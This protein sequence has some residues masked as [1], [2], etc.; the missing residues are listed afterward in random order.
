MAGIEQER[1]DAPERV[2]ARDRTPEPGPAPA[3]S[4]TAADAALSLQRAVGNRR[5]ARI[6][7][8]KPGSVQ[9]GVAPPIDE[10]ASA[11]E[12]GFLDPALAPR[13]ESVRK[14]V[15]QALKVAG[16]VASATPG[17]KVKVPAPLKLLNRLWKT[18]DPEERRK[19]AERLA[20]RPVVSAMETIDLSAKLLKDAFDVFVWTAKTGARVAGHAQMLR[21]IESIERLGKVPEFLGVAVDAYSAV[22]G[23]VKLL[24]PDEKSS[25]RVSGG[26]AVITGSTKA[27]GGWGTLRAG[28]IKLAPTWA[29]RLTAIGT[30][31]EIAHLQA[32][33]LAGQY[34][35]ALTG[36]TAPSV[37]REFD[38]LGGAMRELAGARVVARHI[39]EHWARAQ[40]GQDELAAEA[41]EF[42]LHDALRSYQSSLNGALAVFN[43]LRYRAM[44]KPYLARIDELAKLTDMASADPAGGPLVVYQA[45]E[46]LAGAL[47]TI[48][49]EL[50]KDK[51]KAIKAAAMENADRFH[52]RE[53][54]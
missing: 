11:L 4:R 15:D 7:A 16:A 2:G 10:R 33:F 25:E 35:K 19:L 13:I 40:G 20:G 53:V 9:S 37:E 12:A 18:N 52:G 45:M 39:Y 46:E 3:G 29:V 22:Y 44:K 41:V 31:V 48:A 47:Y 24:D 27:A 6:L 43:R 32:E 38:R 51:D 50:F 54:E 42:E 1:G 49:A 5:T 26:V 14:A 36:T 17:G 34:G 23:V 8:R 21:T 28:G 30:A